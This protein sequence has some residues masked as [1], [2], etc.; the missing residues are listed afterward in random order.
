MDYFF[1]QIFLQ[2]VSFLEQNLSELF[3]L[4]TLINMLIV[5]DELISL[6]MNSTK[7]QMEI[8]KLH[9]LANQTEYELQTAINSNLE[10]NEQLNILLDRSD[11]L[12]HKNQAFGSGLTDYRKDIERKQLINK[13]KYLAIGIL[14]FLII[15]LVIILNIVLNHK[16]NLS[17]R[18]TNIILE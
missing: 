13:F 9:E 10:R 8:N 5:N 14:L 2:L 18:N 16:N 1:H 12:L 15:V 6:N 17:N 4:F 3:S 7:N 11:L